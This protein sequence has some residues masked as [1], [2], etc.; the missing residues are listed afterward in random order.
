MYDRGK[1]KRDLYQLLVRVKHDAQ[2]WHDLLLASGGKLELQKYCFH[3]IFYVFFDKNGVP[4]TRKISNLVIKLENERNEVIGIR[5]KKINKVRTNVGHL[6][7]PEQIK[8][9]KHFPVSLKKAI[10]TSEVIFT[11]RVTRKGV[12]M[13]Y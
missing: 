7:E 11:A 9:P 1:T 13:L 2:L 5:T 3:L 8:V 6:K 12:T 10:E 4:S